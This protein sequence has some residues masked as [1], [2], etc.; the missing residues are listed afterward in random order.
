[1]CYK[2]KAGGQVKHFGKSSTLNCCEEKQGGRAWERG[3]S[4]NLESQRSWNFMG[5]NGSLPFHLLV[6]IYCT[7]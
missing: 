7:A 2:P 4:W 6:Y 5:G 1:L 3:V